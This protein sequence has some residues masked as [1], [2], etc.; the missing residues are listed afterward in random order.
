MAGGS[1]K[2]L[3]GGHIIFTAEHAELMAAI[4]QADDAAKVATKNMQDSAKKMS[5]GFGSVA[6]SIHRNPSHDEDDCRAFTCA[7]LRRGMGGQV[8]GGL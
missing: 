7:S 1:S 6:E 3:G 8:E 4:R 2:Q 5:E